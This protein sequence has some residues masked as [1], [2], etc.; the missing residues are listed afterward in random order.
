M[1]NQGALIRNS[2][3]LS[4]RGMF[5]IIKILVNNEFSVS[6]RLVEGGKWIRLCRIHEGKRGQD[7]GMILMIPLKKPE[8]KNLM[9]KK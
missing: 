2:V 9:T 7:F 4:T 8:R 3:G 5:E 1:F 6:F